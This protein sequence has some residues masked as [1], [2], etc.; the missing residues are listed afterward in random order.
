MTGASQ[1]IDIAKG[2]VA[3]VVAARAGGLVLAAR[4]NGRDLL[5]PAPSLDAAR[6]DP[7]LSACFPCVPYFGRL[8]G[9]LFFEGRRWDQKPTL[10]GCDARHAT[11]GE[12]WVSEWTVDAQTA[13]S[14]T[15]RY[16]HAGREPGR[17][18]FPF[19]AQEQVRA[20][21]TG[22]EIRLTLANS[23]RRRMPASPGLH[24]YFARHPDTRLTFSA[25]AFWT[26]P[27]IGH[28]GWRAAIPPSLDYATGGALPAETLDHSFERFS[29]EVVIE[30]GGSR[31]IL[32]S[33][34]R[35]LHIYAPAGADYFCLEPI[36]G[37]PGDVATCALDPGRRI[38]FA[39]TIEEA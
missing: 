13:D 20:T 11:H 37:L 29:G 32:R 19:E 14:A 35:H 30:G 16:R 8:Y 36:A 7:R 9:G 12:G 27:E 2:G 38:S 21:E 22:I 39:M 34:A 26:P 1:T 4:K 24:P 31:R 23:G 3:G 28:S 6:R 5:R 17:Y 25:A 15:L 33:D 18:P 10:P